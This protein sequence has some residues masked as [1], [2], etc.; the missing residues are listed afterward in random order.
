[1][2]KLI[3]ILSG[4]AVLLMMLLLQR[5]TYHIALKKTIAIHLVV[6]VI[7]II[8]AAFG[9]FIG[10]LTWGGLRLYGILMLDTFALLFLPA[11]FRME[12]GRLGDFLAAP[13]I[14]VCSIV[15]IPCL[16]DGCCY[17]VTILI[18]GVEGGIKFPSQIVEFSIWVLL[19]LWLLRLQSKG[20][21]KNLLWPIAAI[22]FGIFRFLV[23]F[24]RGSA[25]E[26]KL[27]ILGLPAGRFWSLFVLVMGLVYLFLAFRKHYGRSPA[28]AE[29]LRAVFGKAPVKSK[30]EM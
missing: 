13:I 30:K 10:G 3:S 5:R 27:K 16:I 29:F 8:G 11:L 14:A 17:G 4:V 15:K 6:T 2:M 22:W 1:M 19:T 20:N 9:S 18:N 12:R 7:T 28:P 24:F 23:D 21:H 25:S 26:M